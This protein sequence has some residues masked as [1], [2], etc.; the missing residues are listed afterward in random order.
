[1]HRVVIVVGLQFGDEAKGACVD[2]LCR[3][4]NVRRVI[5]YC[6]GSQAGHRVVLDD[7]RSHVFAQWGSGTFYNVPTYLGP[8]MVINLAAMAREA[9]H[10]EELGIA[11]PFELMEADADC[12]VTT[13]YHW[14]V[15]RAKELARGDARHGSCGQGIGE[16]RAYWLRHGNE[17]IFA[18]DLVRRWG[19]SPVEKLELLRQR[20][21]IEVETD[22]GKLDSIQ[23]TTIQRML[24]YPASKIA[25]ELLELAEDCGF[26]PAAYDVVAQDLVDADGRTLLVFEGSQGILLD[27]NYGFGPHT[28]WS[29]VTPHHAFEM[30]REWPRNELFV[31][32]CLRAFTV[33]HGAGPLPSFDQDLD[34]RMKDDGNPYNPWQGSLRFGHLDLQLLRYACAV[35]KHVDPAGRGVDGLAVSWL[36]HWEHHG[37]CVPEEIPR[38][39]RLFAMETTR[40]ERERLA[41]ELELR[42]ETV[43]VTESSLLAVLDQ[44]FAPVVITSNGPKA[45][46]RAWANREVLGPLPER[47]T[48]IIGNAS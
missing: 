46:D 9:K 40:S 10:L 19:A 45:G 32:G 1:M 28:T 26:W 21:L 48:A 16:T 23:R 39:S 18:K 42:R 6:G 22:L 7:G 5:R 8:H 41:I 30:L 36:D 33:R 44:A 2:H 38:H 29:T 37:R 27:E 25:N 17:A 24:A 15:N 31:L 20:M 11:R 12:L 34:D 35:V 43:P 4:F 14:A 47:A 3:N 13:P